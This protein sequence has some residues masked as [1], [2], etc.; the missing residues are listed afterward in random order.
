MNLTIDLD[1][2]QFRSAAHDAVRKMGANA[3]LLIKEEGRLFLGEWRRRTPPFATGWGKPESA[4]ND[5]AVGEKAVRG[6]LRRVAA[7]LDKNVIRIPRLRELIEKND[8][9]GLQAFFNAVQDNTWRMRKM[10]NAAALPGVHWRA[11]NR[12][13]RVPRDLRNAVIVD[14]AQIGY[15]KHVVNLVGMAKATFNKA[16]QALGARLPSYISRH[17]PLGGYSE[18]RGP[19]FYIIISGQSNVPSAARAVAE[20]VTIRGNKLESE[21]RRIMRRFADT[22]K[23]ETRRKSFQQ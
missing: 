3:E 19:S 7:P 9:A 15:V 14:A 18:G 10:V 8:E 4:R 22:G 21:L 23:I 5:K 13:G 12:R 11:R 2:A 17:G 1:T 20:A 6:D 16:A